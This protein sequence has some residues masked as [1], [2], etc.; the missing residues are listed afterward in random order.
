MT[1]LASVHSTARTHYFMIKKKDIV[2]VHFCDKR[3][4]A[5][6]SPDMEPLALVRATCMEAVKE[7]G[8]H[9]TELVTDA[10]T[11]IS[12]LIS[13]HTYYSLGVNSRLHND[14]GDFSPYSDTH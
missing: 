5:D 9:L 3:E 1:P 12:A 6:K 13:K 10:H 4:A 8:V 14:N 2:D 7:K 11:T